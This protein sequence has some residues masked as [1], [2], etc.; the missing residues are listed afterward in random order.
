VRPVSRSSKLPIKV[1]PPEHLEVGLVDNGDATTGIQDGDSD[2]NNSGDY[3]S[4]DPEPNV[5]LP[6]PINNQQAFV[7]AQS[8]NNVVR[9]FCDQ[10]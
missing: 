10:L 1:Q 7:P 9:M 4:D 2:V 8:N 6:A 5:E 3:G